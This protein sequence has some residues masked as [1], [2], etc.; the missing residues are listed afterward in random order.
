VPDH[1]MHERLDER[2]AYDRQVVQQLVRVDDPLDVEPELG[3]VT[4]PQ[5]QPGRIE[6]PDLAQAR[7][8]GGSAT[9]TADLV[10]WLP[11]RLALDAVPQA[12]GEVEMQNCCRD[13]QQS[14]PAATAVAVQNGGEDHKPDPA[15][16]AHGNHDTGV[17]VLP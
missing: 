16:N 11:S 7:L 13:Q 8:A 12:V 14:P 4:C 9:G 6:R 17:P 15:A 2:W 5:A 3:I 1:A 10:T